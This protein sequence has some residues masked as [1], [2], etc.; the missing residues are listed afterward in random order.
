MI[1][2]VYNE[3]KCPLMSGT[4]IYYWTDELTSPLRLSAVDVS[5][6]PYIRVYSIAVLQ[7]VERLL[8]WV[9][10]KIHMEYIH[11]SHCRRYI[12]KYK[13]HL[14]CSF[15][16]HVYMLIGLI[17]ACV[18]YFYADMDFHKNFVPLCQKMLTRL[19]RVFIHA[20]IHHSSSLP[21]EVV[22]D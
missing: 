2:V 3:C 10:K 17:Y 18:L 19:Y 12:K 16:I 15:F 9:R 6:F 7:Y 4:I 13:Q 8:E 14:T 20:F 5:S 11:T 1:S 21:P 22:C